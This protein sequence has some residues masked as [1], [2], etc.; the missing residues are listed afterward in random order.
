M[1]KPL[2]LPFHEL[3]HCEMV[4][5]VSHSSQDKLQGPCELIFRFFYLAEYIEAKLGA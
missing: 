4:F 5:F 2:A 1:S 3:S